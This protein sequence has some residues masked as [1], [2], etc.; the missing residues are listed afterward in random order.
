MPVGESYA[1]QVSEPNFIA[2]HSW[3]P[4]IHYAKRQKRYKP[5]IGKTVYKDRSIMYASH[6][7]ACILAKYA[8]DLSSMLDLRYAHSGLDKAV[9]A[10]R[11]LGRANYEFSADAVRFARSVSPCIVLCFD[12]TGFFDHLDHSLLKARLREILGVSEIPNDWYKVF[13]HVTQFVKIDL[14]DLEEHPALGPKLRDRRR[15][16]IAPIAEI[17]SAGIQ[18][19]RNPNKFVIPQ[20]TPISSALSNLYMFN[21]DEEMVAA[22]VSAGALY[23]RY[24]DDILVICPTE[25]EKNLTV[26]L[27]AAVERHK[28]EVKEEKCERVVFDACDPKSFQYLGFDV[29]LSGAIIR[30]SSLGRQWRRLKRDLARA[31]RL[32]F[33]D[34]DAGNKGKIYTKKLRRRFSPLGVRNFSLYARRAATAFQTKQIVRQVRR[35]ERFADCKI[36]ALN[37]PTD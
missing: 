8:Y 35:L 14:V 25:S 12:V 37:K 28:L 19:H 31:E 24:S 9:V 30:A 6:R 32:R 20:G 2:S 5:N 15:K 22:C 33:A 3:L 7:D 17:A 21:F 27:R 11:K 16:L 34:G 29:S 13:R 18:F 10:Y 26:T 36:R 23:Q 4:L 1:L